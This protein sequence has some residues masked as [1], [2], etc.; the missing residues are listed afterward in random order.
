MSNVQ[1][2]HVLSIA[3]LVLI[4]GLAGCPSPLGQPCGSVGRCPAGYRC[5]GDTGSPPRCMRACRS[6]SECGGEVR[7]VRSASV[8]VEEIDGYCNELG[9]VALG[10]WCDS[11]PQCAVGLVCAYRSR[12]ECLPGC[13]IDGP[14]VADRT[15]GPGLVCDAS[16]ARVVVDGWCTPACDPE[17]QT[18]CGDTEVC[19]RWD[20]P[21]IGVV[22]TCF[23]DFVPARWC[24]P[25][26]ALGQICVDDVCY[27][28][29]GAPPLA[30]DHWSPALTEPLD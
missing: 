12:Q 20:S 28:P 10:G 4:L 24:E 13:N 7:C 25:Q 17:A 1:P 8:V 14:Y 22:A 11:T 23:P 26:C 29:A 21:G 5:F 18:G 6:D 27:A 19:V 2:S 30:P 3:G 15:C 16:V 9:S